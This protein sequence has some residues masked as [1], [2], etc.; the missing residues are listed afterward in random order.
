MLCW[1]NLR[2]RFFP[3][4]STIICP[5]QGQGI[6][7]G[8]NDVTSDFSS[9]RSVLS[10]PPPPKQLFHL[11]S[12]WRS[13]SFWPWQPLLWSWKELLSFTA[14]LAIY[15]KINRPQDSILGA[16]WK[17]D[18][19]NQIAF[20]FFFFLMDNEPTGWC[21]GCLKGWTFHSEDDFLKTSGWTGGLMIPH[22]KGSSM[23][24]IQTWQ[25]TFT[26]RPHFAVPWNVSGPFGKFK[27][28]SCMC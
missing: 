14:H 26:E 5:S 20:F 4:N 27:W 21:A 6:I 23:K 15:V 28:R 13:N 10:C 2:E 18:R 17:R 22:Y 9:N 1:H 12:W 3:K 16:H 8:E 7:F 11:V 25:V 24:T 19:L